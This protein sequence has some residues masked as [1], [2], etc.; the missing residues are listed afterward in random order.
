VIAT[1]T[2]SKGVP[3]IKTPATGIA[4]FTLSAG[5]KSLNYVLKV[6]NIHSVIGA[7]IIELD[8]NASLS[9][10]PA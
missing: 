7:H 4:T 6:R 9:E 8:K 10:N 5:G 2:G 1:L 3:P